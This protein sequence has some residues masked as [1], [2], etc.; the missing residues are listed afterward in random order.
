M[1]KIAAIWTRVSDSK[2]EEPSLDRQVANVRTWLEEQGWTVPDDRV[3]KV[4]WTSKK[5]LNCPQMQML[6]KWVITGEVK[7]VGMTHLDR[8]SGRPGHMSQIFETFK[9]ANCQLLAKETPLPTGLMG[10]L[11]ALVITLGKAMQVDKADNGA[12]DGLLDRVKRR[13]LP[14][15]KHRLYGYQWATESQLEPDPEHPEHYETLKMIFDFALRGATYHGIQRELEK[16]VMP[17]PTDN[18]VWHRSSIA[19]IVGNPVYAGKYYAL[20][21]EACEPEIRSV[22]QEGNTSSR[23][24]PLEQA[25]YLPE[26]EVVNPPITWEQYLHLQERRRKNKE[27]AQRNAKHSYLLRGLILCE[28]HWGIR[29]E[30]S[31]YYGEPQNKSH[32][33]T[34]PVGG[35]AHAHFNGPQLENTVKQLT[36]SLLSLEPNDFYERI[37]NNEN[38][39]GLQDSLK[40]ELKSLDIRYNRNINAETELEHRNLMGN[41][42]PE[43]YRRL[44]VKYEAERNW[45]EERT[46]A[47]NEEMAQ[48]NREAEAIVSLQQ[49]KD[50]FY[51]RLDELTEVEWRELFIALNLRIH[52]GRHSEPGSAELRLS[53]PDVSIS[54]FRGKRDFEELQKRQPGPAEVE[55]RIG[56]P[57]GESEEIVSDIVFTTPLSYSSPF[58][59]RGRGTQGDGVHW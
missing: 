40:Y 59:S 16:R 52:V 27:L 47:I 49:V 35:C 57:L 29:G 2:Q 28:T 11:V 51:R 31:K 5:I 3:I 53:S 7:A 22:V 13:R 30:P 44:K 48:L 36:R 4:V 34:C 8:L 56:L 14:T 15:S 50:R 6:L 38:K 10:E 42:H 43:V 26:V 1:N 19:A 37:A 41:Q 18:P 46:Q 45:I 17:S 21:H 24:I 20:R 54:H 33:Y 12:K 55:I 58:P 25:T 32:K 39:K 9:E 23:H